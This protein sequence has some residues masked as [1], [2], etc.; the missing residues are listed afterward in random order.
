MYA[1]SSFQANFLF[2]VANGQ[3][4]LHGS[5]ASEFFLGLCR[6]FLLYIFSFSGR[7]FFLEARLIALRVAS[8]ILGILVIMVL[9]CSSRLE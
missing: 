7:E 4:N 8:F 2:G 9:M 6:A 3:M 5:V 1:S